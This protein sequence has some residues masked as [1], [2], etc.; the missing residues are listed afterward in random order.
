MLRICG[1]LDPLCADPRPTRR[2]GKPPAES[3]SLVFSTLRFFFHVFVSQM[4]QPFS[5]L[6]TPAVTSIQGSSIPTCKV[7]H[8]CKAPAQP[9]TAP[10]TSVRLLC[11]ALSPC[12]QMSLTH[13]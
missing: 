3:F 11:P 9:T 6:R 7:Q 10:V 4:Q 5:T 12:S 8:A 2:Q 13:P 1:A